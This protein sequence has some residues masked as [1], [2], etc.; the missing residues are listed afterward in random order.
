MNIACCIRDPLLGAQLADMLMQD[1][2]DYELFRHESAL[3]RVLRHRGGIDLA[4]IDIGHEPAIEDNVLSWLS[5]RNGETLPVVLMSSHWNAPR[6]ALALDS[7]ADDCVSKPFD[8]VELLARIK[9]VLRRTNATPAVCTRVELADFVLDKSHSTLADRGSMIELTPREFALA[10][11][12]FSN[13]GRH[14]A[15]EAISLA[16]WG[17]EK[18]IANRTIEQHVY[19]LRKKINLTPARGVM[20]RTTYGQGYRLEMSVDRPPCAATARAAVS[21]L[22]RLDAERHTPEAATRI[23]NT[24]P[25][26]AFAGGNR[27]GEPQCSDF[28]F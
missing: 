9:A 6:M 17:S 12:F 4:L 8:D 22:A 14:L 1:G 24:S 23:R 21:R 15:R 27:P 3:M 10:W 13:P 25:V 16:I 19:K 5:C 20:L 26:F 11:L 28:N 7:G 18:D 2:L